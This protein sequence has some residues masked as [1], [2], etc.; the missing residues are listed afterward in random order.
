MQKVKCPACGHETI[1]TEASDGTTVLATNGAA[2][3]SEVAGWKIERASPDVLAWAA[4]TFN[5]TEYLEAV[6]EIQETGGGD[7]HALIDELE[8]KL[9]GNA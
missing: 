2:L 7:I 9:P 8:R 1:A 3:P 4:Q 5:E 6:R